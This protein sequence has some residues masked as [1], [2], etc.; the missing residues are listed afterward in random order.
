M[1]PAQRAADQDTPPN[2]ALALDVVRQAVHEVLASELAP[3]LTTLTA[4][5]SNG[6]AR[7]AGD[8]QDIPDRL[9]EAVREIKAE[10]S[11]VLKETRSGLVSLQQEVTSLRKT[12]EQLQPRPGTTAGKAAEASPEHTA[13]LRTTA[14]VSSAGLVCHRDIWEFITAHAGRH[15]HFRVPPQITD[16]GDERVRAA[17]SGRSLISLLISLHSLRH[18]ATDGDGDKELATTLYERIEENLSGLTAHGGPVTITLDDRT[19]PAPAPAPHDSPAAGT[20]TDAT[21]ETPKG[22]TAPP[23]TEQGSDPGEEADPGTV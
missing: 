1:I 19:A 23:L 13:L 15:P 5:D 6:A 11:T 16:E 21:R 4:P 3:V 12:V 7:A 22:S 20:D 8:R 10:L 9:R 2:P 14:R 17:L 18:T